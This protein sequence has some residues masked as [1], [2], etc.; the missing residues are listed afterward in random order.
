MYSSKLFWLLLDAA[1]AASVSEYAREQWLF[2]VE[3]IG[4]VHKSQLVYMCDL[5]KINLVFCVSKEYNESKLEKAQRIG[6]NHV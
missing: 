4:K 5:L 6:E 3:N 2:L 1:T